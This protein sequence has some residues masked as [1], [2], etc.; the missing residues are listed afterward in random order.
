MSKKEDVA[1]AKAKKKSLAESRKKDKI[2]KTLEMK[3]AIEEE[4]GIITFVEA[5]SIKEHKKKLVKDA[6]LASLEGKV[7]K[8]I[9]QDVILE[10]L[11]TLSIEEA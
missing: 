1:F 2:G 8:E 11:K 3:D 6:R 5:L 10:S 9:P 7:S 4:D